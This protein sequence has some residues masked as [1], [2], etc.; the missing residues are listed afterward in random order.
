[1][2]WSLLALLLVIVGQ[3]TAAGNDATP[4]QCT[5]AYSCQQM[6]NTLVALITNDVTD[7][8][9]SSDKADGASKG[10]YGPNKNESSVAKM[11]QDIEADKRQIKLRLDYYEQELQTKF[12]DAK[13]LGSPTITID[14]EKNLVYMRPKLAELKQWAE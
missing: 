1:M 14:M 11:K 10:G 3:A 2:G 5:D 6:V 13:R 8:S 7:T 9:G 4:M 12:D